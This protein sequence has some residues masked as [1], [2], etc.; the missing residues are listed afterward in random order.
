MDARAGGKPNK[1]HEYQPNDN[2]AYSGAK[3]ESHSLHPLWFVRHF[4]ECDDAA[5]REP[6]RTDGEG[7][8][9]QQ[10]LRSKVRVG[11]MHHIDKRR[12]NG[13]EDCHS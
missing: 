10:P 1:H 2:R 12:R 11:L 5:E 4:S 9:E 6:H 8:K 13:N 3:G 7:P